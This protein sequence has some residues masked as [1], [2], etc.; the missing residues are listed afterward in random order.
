MYAELST[1]LPNA[2]ELESTYADRLLI[3]MIPGARWRDEFKK[4]MLPLTWI[5][6]KCLRTTFK[7]ALSIGPNLN[8]WGYATLN[9][10]IAPAL[11][12]RDKLEI[13]EDDDSP[14][15]KVVKSWR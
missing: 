1:N 12:I 2:I 5:S 15:A 10:R 13:D 14:E 6:C 11:A 7:D 9:G 3:K 4:W 8:A